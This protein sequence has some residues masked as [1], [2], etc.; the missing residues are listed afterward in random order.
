ML[1]VAFCF[2]ALSRYCVFVKPFSKLL[3]SLPSALQNGSISLDNADRR[4]CLTK[5]EFL[6]K[7]LST[8]VRADVES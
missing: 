1:F 7:E 2:S 3:H 8:Q 5:R 6:R 4:G